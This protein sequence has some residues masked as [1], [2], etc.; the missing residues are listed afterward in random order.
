MR[1]GLVGWV[2]NMSG[3]Q[4]RGV[5]LPA[6]VDSPC[7]RSVLPD[8]LSRPLCTPLASLQSLAQQG[9]AERIMELIAALN[10]YALSS[11]ARAAAA[12]GAGQQLPRC[13][14]GINM[15]LQQQQVCQR[16]A[17]VPARA[18][19]Q[20]AAPC[21]PPNP[22]SLAATC[23]PQSNARK[24]G[25]LGLAA[26]AVGLAAA[27]SAPPVPGVLPKIV[28]PILNSFTDADS[29]VR[30]YAAEALYNVVRGRRIYSRAGAALPCPAL[31]ATA[32]PCLSTHKAPRKSR[33]KNSPSLL[34]PGQ[35]K[36]L[37]GQFMEVFGQSFEALFKICSDPDPSV[38]SAATFLDRL[39]KVRPGGWGGEVLSAY[40]VPTEYHAPIIPRPLFHRC[41]AANV[42]TLPTLNHGIPRT[43][44]RTLWRRA[45]PLTWRGS[46]PCWSSTSLSRTHTSASSCSAGWACWTRCLSRWVGGW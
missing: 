10:Q 23:C 24:G 38:Q 9:N 16:P 26:T 2:G 43:G 40:V 34:H 12:A 29:R 21:V 7:L 11:Q 22:S 8:E 3:A 42:I 37:R 46:Y 31:P 13:L 14:P 30:Y 25:L 28:P 18:R 19:E 41:P 45:T 1:V 33:Q 36:S 44:R 5:L 35:A 6:G 27:P 4:C 32:R 17:W 39:I 20:A 15:L